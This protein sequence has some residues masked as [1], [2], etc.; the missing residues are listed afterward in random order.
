MGCDKLPKINQPPNMKINKSS[1][2]TYMTI[3]RRYAFIMKLFSKST[4]KVLNDEGARYDFFFNFYDL[5][6]I[7]NTVCNPYLYQ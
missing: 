4:V 5:C 7:T 6:H 1:V 3:Y 2:E